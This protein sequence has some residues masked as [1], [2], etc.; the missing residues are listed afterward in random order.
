MNHEILSGPSFSI[1]EVTLAAGERIVSEAGAMAWMDGNVK[2]E[3]TTRGGVLAGL[4]RAVFSGETFFQNTYEADGGPARIA[5]APGVSGE[6]VPWQLQG[7]DL[8][9]QRGAYLASTEGI[10]CESKSEGL[11][12][13]FAQ[14]LFVL[15]ATGTGTMFFSGYGAIDEIDL[16]GGSSYTIDNGYVVAWE[17]TLSYRI[18]RARKIRSFL[19]SDQLLLSFSGRGRVWINSRSPQSLASWV[20]PFRRVKSKSSGGGIQ[21]GP[22]N[23][24]GE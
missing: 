13:L 22:V 18:T 24:G 19:F 23:L 21:I 11:K 7:E 9:L 15:R 12:G 2:T 17:P 6:I 5:F 1:L 4:K 16:D 3:T 14:G 10:R 20:H 8:L